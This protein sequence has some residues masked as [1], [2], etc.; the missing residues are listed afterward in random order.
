PYAYDD[1]GIALSKTDARNL[2]VTYSHDALHRLTGRR[3]PDGSAD[4]Y[5]WDSV[6]W[7]SSTNSVGR[8]VHA[9]NN[10]NAAST[11]SYDV[12]GHIT[13]EGNWTP[14]APAVGANPVRAAYDL[15]GNLSTLTY[16]SG[17]VVSYTYTNSNQLKQVQLSDWSGS[18]FQ[19]YTYMSLA[20][21]N[22]NPMDV[23]KSV[24]FGNGTVESVQY[25]TRLQPD[26][27][28]VG[29]PGVATYADHVYGFTAAGVP[30]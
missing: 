14:S 30:G 17:R 29:Q 19:S 11:F 6:P 13:Y 10:A 18:P 12:M 5:L 3:F 16:P 8:L 21:T 7:F 4:T 2:T 26:E 22:F 28:S 24:T 20:D 9:T 1:D 27:I 25:N 23:P 15:A